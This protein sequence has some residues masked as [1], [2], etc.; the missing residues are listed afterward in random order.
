M[1]SYYP[2]SAGR[3]THL[4]LIML[5][6]DSLGY[7]RPP[8]KLDLKKEAK[9]ESGNKIVLGVNCIGVEALCKCSKEE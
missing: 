3:S 1:H 2:Y 8:K 5:V 4:F 6:N 9:F 7:I